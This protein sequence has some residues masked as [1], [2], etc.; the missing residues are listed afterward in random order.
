M[1]TIGVVG[2]GAAGVMTAAHLAR[3]WPSDRPL[4]VV[5]YDASPRPAR[6][7]AYSTAEP[8]HLLNIPAGRMSAVV[9]D[10]EHF[11][12]WVRRQDPA[13]SPGDFRSRGDYGDYL[14]HTL[15]DHAVAIGLVVRRGQ[16]SDVTRSGGQFRVVHSTGTDVVDAVVL[17]LGHTPPTRPSGVVGSAAG[18]IADPWA[19]GALRELEDVT[20]R[21]DTV[22]TIGTGLTAVDIALS[23]SKRGRRVIAV[24]R[25]G[26]LPTRHRCPPEEPLPPPAELT[27][28]GLLT[29]KELVRLVERHVGL[30]RSQ[31]RSWRAAIDGLRPITADLWRRLPPEERRAFLDGP[32]RRW[33]VRRHRMAP[34]I[35]S[36]ID[37][38]VQARVLTVCR[39]EV[40]SARGEERQWRVALRHDG[41]LDH[42]SVAA[43][44]NCTGPTCDITR[45]P[46][47][48]GHRLRSHGLVVADPLGLGI[49][50]D[51]DGAVVDADGHA[52]DRL[53]TLGSWRRGSL[54]E[55]TAVPELREQA[56]AVAHRLATALVPA[57][58]GNMDG[59]ATRSSSTSAASGSWSSGAALSP[60]G[61]PEPS[62]TRAPTS[63]SLLLP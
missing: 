52:D 61:E 43:V 20:R 5:L 34:S 59:C 26:L 47:G 46:S 21:G 50:T 42:L 1:T 10:D 55:S 30:A 27:T 36:D 25:H 37:R 23:L 39:G 33:E 24:S 4:R 31:G 60:Y 28:G 13:A 6:G 53:L 38:L 58:A 14:A 12:R 9:D 17:A 18:Y 54:Y 16:V 62:S 41:V 44:V 8:H 49:V 29:A 57:A 19:P 48:L 40:M 35:A 3:A 45:V 51:T 15:A 63:S 7:V 56:A 32:A 22:L 2:G 11:L